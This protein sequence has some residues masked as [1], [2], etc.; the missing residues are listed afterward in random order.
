MSPT[1]RHGLQRRCKWGQRGTRW[2]IILTVASEKGISERILK[3][4]KSCKLVLHF[5]IT[6]RFR[7]KN[8]VLS[9]YFHFYPG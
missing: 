7:K 8:V 9:C 3:D 4:K 1:A 6:N 5:S 2:L